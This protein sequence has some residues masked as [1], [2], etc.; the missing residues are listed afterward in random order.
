MTFKSWSLTEEVKFIQDLLLTHQVVYLGKFGLWNVYSAMEARSKMPGMRGLKKLKPQQLLTIPEYKLHLDSLSPK[1][2]EIIPD[3]FV[4][5]V[6][7]VKMHCDNAANALAKIGFPKYTATMVFMDLKDRKNRITGGGVG[8]SAHWKEHAFTVERTMVSEGTIVHEHAHMWW[9]NVLPKHSKDTF[10]KWYN[11]NVKGWA[12]K[13]YEQFF[14]PENIDSFAKTIMKGIKDYKLNFVHDLGEK[15]LN[16]DIQSY[17]DLRTAVEEGKDESTIIEKSVMSRRGKFSLATLKNDMQFKQMLRDYNKIDLPK[18][19]EVMVEY[20]NSGYILNYFIQEPYQR[21][22]STIIPF[23][24]LQKY[25][26]FTMDKL[27]DEEQQQVKDSTKLAKS[28]MSAFLAPKKH[29]DAIRELFDQSIEYQFEYTKDD[30][31]YQYGYNPKYKKGYASM[32]GDWY[33]TWVSMVGRRGKSSVDHPFGKLQTKEDIGNVFVDAAKS[34]LYFPDDMIPINLKDKFQS[35]EYEL[36]QS[37]D[38]PEGRELR[39]KIQKSGVVPSIYAASNYDELWAEVVEKTALSK[40]QVSKELKQLLYNIL[41]G[42]AKDDNMFSR[43]E[44]MASRLPRRMQ[45]RKKPKKN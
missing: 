19:S 26:T 22:E 43:Q 34:K 18:G 44:M 39:T 45:R 29:A 40:Q 35:K 17:L 42:T 31:G 8:G 14:D 33:N 38:K 24:M 16:R 36:Q 13:N 37:L 4:D 23:N 30:D 1:A 9:D 20:V 11:E 12:G 5:R 3:Y 21:F 7:D 32:S 6:G 2:I 28:K 27:N 10:I 41:T 15:V 25:V